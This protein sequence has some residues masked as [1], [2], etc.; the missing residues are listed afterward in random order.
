[1]AARHVQGRVDDRRVKVTSILLVGACGQRH[2]VSERVIGGA[3]RC[4]RV[5]GADREQRVAARAHGPKRMLPVVPSH[6]FLEN[7]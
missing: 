3:V 2:P 4:R 5:H 7:T 1:M 6:Q